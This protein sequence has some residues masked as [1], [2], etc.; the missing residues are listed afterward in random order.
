[1]LQAKGKG[2]TKFV[3]VE[4]ETPALNQ[5]QDG[6]KEKTNIVTSPE[7]TTV[8]DM[9]RVPKLQLLAVVEGSSWPTERWYR[10]LKGKNDPKVLFDPKVDNPSQQFDCIRNLE[11]RVTTALDRTQE[12]ANKTY[13]MTGAATVVNSVPVNE[14]DFFTASI[15][16]GRFGLFTITSSNRP[17]N[18]KISTYT[19]EYGMLYE[20]TP[21]HRQVLE[22]CTV[23]TYYYIKERAFTGGDTLLTEKE[24]RRFLE[25]GERITSI[26]ETYVKR[27]YNADAQTLLYPNDVWGYA[28]DVFLAVFVRALG[29]RQVGKDIRIYPHQRTNVKDVETL[30]SLIIKQDPLFLQDANRPNKPFQTRSFRTLQV[31]NNVGWSKIFVTRFFQADMQLNQQLGNWEPF[32]AFEPKLYPLLGADIPLFNPITYDPYILS[33]EFYNGSYTSV[34][35]YALHLYLNKQPLDSAIAAELGVEV[36]KLPRDSQFYYVPLVYVL[37]KYAR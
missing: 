10:S 22:A 36:H 5:P 1:M 27:F 3:P 16:D 30:F 12:G 31:A 26:E 4:P 19:V 8:I 35:E 32:T 20:V 34:I 7:R 9:E 28:Y 29:L 18:N 25:L 15:G 14:G 24:Y 11:L 2:N 33:T 37:L 13:S 21:F 17:S 23:R 6:V